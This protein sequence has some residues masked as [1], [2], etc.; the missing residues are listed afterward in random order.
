MHNE[1]VGTVL[2]TQKQISEKA[3]EIGRKIEEDFRGESVVLVGIL[4]GAVLWMADIM[5]NVNLDMTIDFMSVSSYGSST[6]S[7][8][9]VKINKDLDTDIEGQNVIIVEDIV[10]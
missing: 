10:D 4:R 3:A 1:T 6:K 5:K 9:I 2:I 8:G 7:S